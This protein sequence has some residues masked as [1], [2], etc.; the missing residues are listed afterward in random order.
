MRAAMLST[1]AVSPASTIA[2]I[3]VSAASDGGEWNRFVEQHPLA[4]V[5]HLWQWRDLFL[6]VFGLDTEYLIARQGTL[7]IGVLPLV[8]FKSRLFGRQVVS[9]PMLNYGG[10]LLDNQAAVEPLLRAATDIVRNFGGAHLELRHQRRMTSLPARQHKVSM[11]RA[12]PVDVDVLWNGIDRKVRN[13]VRKAQKA[14]LSV[15]TGRGELVGQFYRVFSEN[16]RDLGTPVYAR[17]WFERI[18]EV[19]PEHARLH[20]VSHDGTAI[21]AS[22]VLRFRD[23]DLVPWASSLRSYRHLCPNM[24]LYWSMLEAAVAR[25]ARV[26]DFGR[27]SPDAGTYQFKM[28]WGAEP[29]PQVWEYVLLR[30]SVLPDQGPSN[31]RFHAAVSA[32]KRLPLWAANRLGPVIVRNIP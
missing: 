9:L 5:D 27:S 21:A 32:W 11:R 20:V 25:G 1:T 12:L 4:T 15:A 10:M 24:L 14:N 6:S 31:G 23:T 18:L 30:N 3:V 16:M 26:F 22:C 28:Q 29:E 8:L 17:R 2:P 7:V 19:F 13:Q